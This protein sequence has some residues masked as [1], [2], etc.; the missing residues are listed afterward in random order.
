MQVTEVRTVDFGG[1]PID[2]DRRVL[3]PRPWTSAQAEWA[4]ELAGDAPEGPILELCCGAG[5]IGLMAAKLSG[6]PLVQVDR[7]EVAAGYARRNAERAGIASEIRVAS[8]ES[9]F[10]PGEAFPIVVADPP[11]LPTALVSTFPDDPVTAVDGGTDGLG[12]VTLAA[13]V[14]LE[15]LVPAGHLVLQVGT[16]EQADYIARG[17]EQQAPWAGPISAAVAD[18]RSGARGVLVHVRRQA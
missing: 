10:S 5:Q 12:L 6:R 4:A 17:L 1:I 16:D 18:R 3:E 11:W 15:H 2:W 14:A 9:A 8:M 13:R 7:D